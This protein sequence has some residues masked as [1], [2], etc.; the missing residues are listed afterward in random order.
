MIPRVCCKVVFIPVVG[1]FTICSLNIN[2]SQTKNLSNIDWESVSLNLFSGVHKIWNWNQMDSLVS[3]ILL[4]RK[5]NPFWR[6]GGLTEHSCYKVVITNWM[7]QSR[8]H[9]LNITTWVLQKNVTKWA[10]QSECYKVVNTMCVMLLT[11][12]EFFWNANSHLLFSL[13]I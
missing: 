13:I 8:Y 7:L 6:Y 5:G 3:T 2:E 10:L 4:L 9:K 11:L 12:E 1:A